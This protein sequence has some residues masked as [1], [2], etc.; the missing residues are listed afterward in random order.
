MGS[1]RR[2]RSRAVARRTNRDEAAK[3][4]ARTSE[5]VAANVAESTG[6][7][8]RR[9]G[10]AAGNAGARPRSSAG[11][12]A[13]PSVRRGKKGARASGTTAERLVATTPRLASEVGRVHR[14]RNGTGRSPGRPSAGRP[15][16]TRG[17]TANNAWGEPSP[18]RAGARDAKRQ[19]PE[20]VAQHRVRQPGAERVSEMARRPDDVADPGTPI[21][22]F[23]H[24]PEQGA[25]TNLSRTMDTPRPAATRPPRGSRRR[26]SRSSMLR[27]MNVKKSRSATRRMATLVRKPNPRLPP[28]LT[29]W[30]P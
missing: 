17:A 29:D 15:G 11:R 24:R 6:R 12:S 25:A 1:R 23:E 5:K 8:A 27:P 3:L 21:M 22:A 18:T 7:A 30:T 10:R 4:S 9:P 16:R 19:P 13:R 26:S 14:S 28:V 20:D 2:G